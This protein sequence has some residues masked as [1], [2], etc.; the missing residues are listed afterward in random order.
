MSSE[1]APDLSGIIRAGDGIILGQACAEP[2]AL[3]RA[4][5]AQ[6]ASFAGASVFLGVNYAGIIRP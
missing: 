2:Q 6:R 5:V 3:S 1:P 4:L